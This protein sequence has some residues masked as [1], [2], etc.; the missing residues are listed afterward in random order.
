M[1]KHLV[2]R[3][4]APIRV[5]LNQAEVP[6]DKVDFVELIG[7]CTRVPAIK[8]RVAD[9]FN[10]EG[11]L[12]TTLN[13]DEAVARGCAFQVRAPHCSGRE[14]KGAA[15]VLTVKIACVK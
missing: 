4:E 2:E 8:Q 13:Q 7:G 12:S 11:I 1:I 9:F 3:V 10:R 6:K 5:A 15:S 14:P